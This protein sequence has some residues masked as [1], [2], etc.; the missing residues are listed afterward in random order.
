[1]LVFTCASSVRGR[2]L[3]I[4]VIRVYGIAKVENN[5]C[6]VGLNGRVM[7]LFVGARFEVERDR[8]DE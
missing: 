7:L 3:V 8:D 4:L 6:D 1:S 5:P 2:A